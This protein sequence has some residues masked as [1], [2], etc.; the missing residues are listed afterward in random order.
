MSKKENK[1]PHLPLQHIGYC[2]ANLPYDENNVTWDDFVQYAK[3]SLCQITK[4]LMKDPIWDE[5]R[6]EEILVEYY[7]HI[8]AVNKEERAKFEAIMQGADEDIHDW[9]DS[10]IEKNQ[11]E[12]DA[13]IKEM[14]LEDS[15]SFTPNSLGESDG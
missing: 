7:A 12:T 10:M 9:L 2:W 3:F 8:Y 1:N 5:Y 15:L 11:A 13:K 4:R 14:G 6:E